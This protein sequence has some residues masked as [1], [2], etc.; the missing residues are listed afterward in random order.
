MWL[1]RC[2]PQEGVCIQLT[3]F[4]T[5]LKSRYDVDFE[6]W[7]Q[8]I[9]ADFTAWMYFQPSNLIEEI[10]PNLEA[11]LT[12]LHQQIFEETS[13]CQTANTFSP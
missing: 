8:N 7:I 9:Q 10:S 5:P 4:T 1:Q 2:E 3:S 6:L 12:D 13:S 11:H